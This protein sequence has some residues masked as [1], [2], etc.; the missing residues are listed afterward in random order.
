MNIFTINGHRCILL[1]DYAQYTMR[2]ISSV[3]HL[4]FQGNGIR[5]L[6]HIRVNSTTYIPVNEITG[7]P[8][9]NPGVQ[10]LGLDIYHNVQVDT[11]V[12]TNDPIYERQ[13]CPICT[14]AKDFCEARRAAEEEEV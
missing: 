4:V 8:N 10:K 7:Y 3:R 12:G 13:L 2:S 6:K 1:S 14:Y 9:I 5:K 11:A